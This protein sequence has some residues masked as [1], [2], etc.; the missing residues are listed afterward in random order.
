[1]TPPNST[2]SPGKQAAIVTGAGGGL[3]RAIA[4][5]LA[6]DGFAVAVIDVDA[7]DAAASEREI[8]ELGGTATSYVVDLRDAVAIERTVR[9]VEA[10][11]GPVA[12]LVNNAAVF[13]AGPM[14]DVSAEQYDDTIAVNQRAYFLAAQATARLMIAAERSGAIVNLGSITQHGGWSDMVPYATT[15]G[16]AATMTRALA[17]ELG[18]FEIRVNCVAPGAFPTRAEKMHA[19]P[20]AY[21]QR[22]IDS[23]ALKRRGRPDEVA[24]AVSFLIGPDSAFV[25]G[26][27]LNVDGGWIMA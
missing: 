2:D 8:V 18:P 4:L 26:Q 12:A 5:R 14:L 3:G 23:Q 20:E 1:M 27:T 21:S 10:D 24:A 17:T 16:A 6:T 15:K 19:D 11:L 13:P 22:I 7:S 9:Q 25:T